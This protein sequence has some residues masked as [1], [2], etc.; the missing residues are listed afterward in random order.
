MTFRRR[1]AV[2]ALLLGVGACALSVTGA[3]RG[4][5][6]LTAPAHAQGSPQEFDRTPPRPDAA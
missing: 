5:V 4:G 1:V 3:P 2:S 6:S